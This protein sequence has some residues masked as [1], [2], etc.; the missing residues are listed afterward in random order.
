[1]KSCYW[2]IDWGWIEILIPLTFRSWKRTLVGTF[3]WRDAVIGRHLY[4]ALPTIM[5][6]VKSSG[7]SRMWRARI[8]RF[9]DHPHLRRSS[10]RVWLL[11]FS[12]L[13]PHLSIATEAQNSHI[14][15]SP[16]F[17]LHGEEADRL[18]NSWWYPGDALRGTLMWGN[19]DEV[20]I[21]GDRC[22]YEPDCLL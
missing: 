8:S 1:M 15:R 9:F 19:T 6:L 5:N 14:G 3:K 10:G 2:R 21:N 4:S 17:L 13:L 11:K 20:I 12:G 16:F 18:Q 7:P 22:R